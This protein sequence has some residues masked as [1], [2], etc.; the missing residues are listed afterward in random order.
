VR[1]FLPPGLPP[2]STLPADVVAGLTTAAVVLPKAM[3]YATI[4]GLPVQVGLYTAVIPM[5]IYAVLGTSRPLSV[6]TTTTLAILTAAELGNVAPD[7]A[8]ERLLAATAT[9]AA[10]TGV[11]LVLAGLLRLGFLAKFI[12][13]PVLVGFK[14]GIG[15]VV[16]VD[17]LPKFLGVHIDKAG[18]LHNLVATLAQLSHLSTPTLVIAVVTVGI[19]VGLEQVLPKS[20]AP[21]IA[22]GVAIA[23]SAGFGLEAAGVA[24]VGP[25]PAGLPHL[26]LPDLSLARLLWPGALGIA[27][28]SFTESIAAGRAFAEKGEPRPLPDRELLATGA[29]NLGGGF[30][31]AM[32]AGGGT[33]QTAVNRHAGARTQMAGLVTA[34]AGVAT[35]LFLA[36]VLALMPMAALAAVVIATSVPLIHL[37]SFRRI[38]RFRVVEFTWA[39]AACAGVMFLGTLNGILVAVV[40]SLAALMYLANNPPV[41]VM[42]RKP[43]TDVFRP[44]SAEHPEDERVPGLLILRADGRVHFANIENIGDKMW[45][46]IY[47]AHPRV[48]LL[49]CSGIVGFEYTS[50]MMFA[51]GEERLRAEGMELWLAELSPEALAQVQRSSLGP[52]LGRERMHFTLAL[53]V[54]AFKARELAHGGTRA[55]RV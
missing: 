34:V 21:L 29:A 54:E 16:V 37:P 55:P 6:S 38:Y 33:S 42:V 13:E 40:L 18:W 32:P 51:E 4:A 3:A 52:R 53:A 26:V 48:V 45:P 25:I 17:Q 22:V 11:F 31:G 24:I 36:P 1:A 35:L 10:L 47:E 8:P 39:V 30:F 43:G 46:L 27:L 9:L 2:P 50:L 14:A 15:L 19:L 41:Y 28:M 23:I 49:D 7:G 12:S 44:A 20:P 5:A